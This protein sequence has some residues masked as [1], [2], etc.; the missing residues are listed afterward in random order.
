MT[1][2]RTIPGSEID[3]LSPATIQ[4]FEALRDNPIAIAEQASGAP[5]FASKSKQVNAGA[6]TDVDITGLDDFSGVWLHCHFSTTSGTPNVDVEI[7]TD[8]TT[9]TGTTLLISMVS[10]AS[11]SATVYLDFATGSLKSAILNNGAATGASQTIP[12][13]SLSIVSVRFK[14]AAG[15]SVAVLAE[16][17]GGES[18]S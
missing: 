18:A 13:A 7:S 14:A 5:K 11:A 9:F 6:S 10:P 17:N 16:P 8:G 15:L 1:T 12:G 3:H 2:H 4:L